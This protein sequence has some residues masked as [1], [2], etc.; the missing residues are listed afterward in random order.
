MTDFVY[1]REI[2]VDT[3]IRPSD[4]TKFPILDAMSIIPREIFVPRDKKEVAYIGANL[5]LDKNR[6]ILEPRT[7]AKILDFL[8][9]SDDELV[10]VIGSGLGYSAALISRLSEA[11][12]ALEDDQP[13]VDESEELLRE[14]GADN[15]IVEFGVL[16]EGAPAHGPY[17]VILIEG[18]VQKI[19][20]ILI[21]Q[22][23]ED[24]RIACIFSKGELGRV[25]IGFKKEKKINW[26]FLFNANA[27][28]L[29]GF[30]LERRF[31][32]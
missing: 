27:P 15:V 26:K 6:V 8:N 4:V 32:L 18:A 30:E 2:M 11:V 25:Q 28:V 24:G 13:R 29:K 20:D 3:Q 14:I 23:K 9:I 10:L 21:N 16:R 31:V 19:P 7:I 5:E 22:L 17:D 1:K 12:V